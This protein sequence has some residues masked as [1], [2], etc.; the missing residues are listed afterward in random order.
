MVGEL[1]R[2]RKKKTGTRKGSSPRYEAVGAKEASGGAASR[3]IE[4]TAAG[5][6]RRKRGAA[7]SDGE[8]EALGRRVLVLAAHTSKEDEEDQRGCTPT[9]RG[10]LS[11]GNGAAAGV[12]SGSTCARMKRCGVCSGA[13]RV[14]QG[15]DHDLYRPRSGSR[16]S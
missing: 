8:G 4:A 2:T 6:R 7:R 10:L 11:A 5:S 1:V 15:L 3:E 13:E 16:K 14:R 9:I 12:S